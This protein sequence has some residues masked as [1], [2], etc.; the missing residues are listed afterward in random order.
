MPSYQTR[1]SNKKASEMTLMERETQELATK[2]RN[3]QRQRDRDPGKRKP[4]TSA[5]RIKAM[6]KQAN[7]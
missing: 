3:E 1:Y 7:R 2:Y 6:N 5:G 4:P